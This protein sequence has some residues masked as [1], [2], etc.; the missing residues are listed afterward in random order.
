MVQPADGGA[1]LPVREVKRILPGQKLL[2]TPVRLD[3]EEKKHGRI[4]IV[5]APPGDGGD[6]VQILDVKKAGEPAEWTIPFPVGVV[7]LVFG[8]QGLDSKKIASMINKDRE[9]VAQL[10]DY[11]EQTS[12]AEAL[13]EALMVYDQREPNAARN[14][15]AALAGFA[16]RYGANP[17]RIDRNAPFEQQAMVM[18]R[19]INPALAT[20]D[21]L[22][23][24]PRLRM[25]Q[26][27]GL[28]ASV[29]GLFLG[30]PVGLAAGSAALFMNMRTLMFPDTEFRSSFVQK[31]NDE[32]KEILSLCAKRQAMKS[33]TRMAYLWA[34]R[35]PNADAPAISFAP[36]VHVPIG[37]K[38]A[39]PIQASDWR[40]L[41]RARRWRLVRKDDGSQ[42]RLRVKPLLNERALELDLTASPVTEGLYR[43][44]AKWDWDDLEV[45]GDV[46]VHALPNLSEARVTTASADRLVSGRGLVR[47]DLEGA[48]F[49]FVEKVEL[50][51]AENGKAV[52]TPLDFTLPRGSRAGEQQ[53]LTVEIDT[54]VHRA[55]RYVLLLTHPDGK[56]HEIPSRVLPPNPSFQALPVRVNLGEESQRIV[57]RGAGLDRVERFESDAATVEIREVPG[58][59]QLAVEVRLSPEVRKGDRIQLRMKVEGMEELVAVPDVL[60]VAGPRPRILEARASLPADLGIAMKGDELPAGSFASLSIRAANVDRQA[61]IHLRCAEKALTVEPLSLRTGEQR[62]GNRLGSVGNGGMFLSFDPG[63]VG[64]MGCTLTAVAETEQEG[65]SDAYVLGRVVRLPRIESFSLTDEQLGDGVYAGVLKGQD[66]ETIER[67]GWNAE[68]GLPVQ[69]LPTPVAGEGHKQTLKIALPWPSPAPRSPLFIWL[70]GEAEGRQ[71][72]ARY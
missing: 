24:E 5:V 32:S 26:S 38:S 37:V 69:G 4:A 39:A 42:A 65:S 60:A 3:A 53:Q 47:V 15:D 45:E 9:L 51:T 13:I 56:V 55:G 1:P 31:D 11:A 27:A 18:M 50:R 16:S 10:A 48:D 64:Q 46:Y 20:Y 12:H 57:L 29:A 21:P 28:A 2:Y 70:R 34:L 62:G 43:L 19:S 33:R 14:L 54:N 59:S 30:N 7:A 66:L 52:P 25:M 41:D 35:V 17:A 36:T 68:E 61:S 63:L 23:P 40:L 22:T 67:A 71:T 49:E 72:Q 58:A 6:K 8:P 44:T